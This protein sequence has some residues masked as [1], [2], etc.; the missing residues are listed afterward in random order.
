[1]LDFSLIGVGV[2]C[3]ICGYVG[4][5]TCASGELEWLASHFFYIGNFVEKKSLQSKD[6]YNWTFKAVIKEG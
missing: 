5:G 1:M 3:V 6:F 4:D 2:G